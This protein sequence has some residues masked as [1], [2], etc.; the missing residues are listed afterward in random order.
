MVS[1]FSSM[2]EIPSSPRTSTG[3]RV[4][5]RKGTDAVWAAR[6]V[7]WRAARPPLRRWVVSLMRIARSCGSFLLVGLVGR[8][9]P[10]PPAGAARVGG[11]SSLGQGD[12]ARQVRVRIGGVGE[13]QRRHE[14]LLEAGLD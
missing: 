8:T 7:A 9:G 1:A 2:R 11:R 5:V 10:P 3:A 13:R 6:R 14:V 12:D 4:R